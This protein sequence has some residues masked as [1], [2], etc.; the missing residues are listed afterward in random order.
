[1]RPVNRGAGWLHHRRPSS[2]PTYQV[3]CLRSSQGS[4]EGRLASPWLGR[5][6]ARAGTSAPAGT[7]AAGTPAHWHQCCLR[8]TPKP[9]DWLREDC[10]CHREASRSQR[11]GES[12]SDSLQMLDMLARKNIFELYI[13]CIHIYVHVY[14]YVHFYI[15]RINLYIYTYVY[16]YSLKGEY[17]R[18]GIQD[19]LYAHMRTP[20]VYIYIMRSF[21]EICI[22]IKK[23]QG[24]IVLYIY[25]YTS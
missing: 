9:R 14:I 17:M 10:D 25:I 1:M 12:T 23:L 4:G 15:Q 18:Q 7:P 22:F 2:T 19:I 21:R 24:D 20:N 8:S 3:P 6:W 13:I 16:V 5:I 11:S